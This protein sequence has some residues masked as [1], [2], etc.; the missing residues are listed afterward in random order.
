MAFVGPLDSFNSKP[1]QT[2]VGSSQTN[3]FTATSTKVDKDSS[4][5]ITGGTTT[6]YYSASAGNYVQAATT[7]DGG[8][9]WTYLKDSNGKEILGVDAKNSL[10]KGALKN[11]TQSQ[12][13]SAT[14]NKIGGLGGL[15]Q[16]EQKIVADS[17][18]NTAT[19]QE[20]ANTAG[21]AP[22]QEYDFGKVDGEIAKVQSAI[23]STAR[24]PKEYKNDQYPIDLDLRTQD[25]IQFT[26]IEYQPQ[27]VST[28]EFEKGGVF[29]GRG[30]TRNRG[31]TITLPIQP[32][33]TDNNAV[34][35]SGLSVD[36]ASALMSAAATGAI[37]S[38]GE[39]VSAALEGGAALLQSKAG[40]ESIKSAIALGYASANKN[41]FTKATGA[42]QNPNLELLFDSPTLRQFTFNFVMSARE[43]LESQAIRRIIR[44]FKQGMSVKKSN[45][46]LFLKSPHTFDIKYLNKREDHKYLNK[47]KECAL[48]NFT[49]DY[50][51][52]GNYSTY[53]NGSMT[54]YAMSMTFQE[55]DPIYDEDY[56][57][58]GTEDIGY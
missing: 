50:T 19:T 49:V 9:T 26:M 7:T 24:K 47:I 48:L 31:G 10:E 56:N 3:I 51:P 23:T 34:S 21:S 30:N 42:V 22:A 16:E 1:I 45:T 4:G 15:N 39:G 41:F 55:L 5:K 2:K 29:A 25:C 6:L 44:F 28:A 17:I 38:G 52:A 32:S 46:A 11:N 40:S 12:I 36:A 13:I 53:E 20:E 57:Q 43:E 35:W 18:K 33:I 27:K 8:K 37:A 54:L 14:K 58:F